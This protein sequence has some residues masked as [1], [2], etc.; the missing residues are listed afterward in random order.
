MLL[1]ALS[2]AGLE[3]SFVVKGAGAVILIFVWNIKQVLQHRPWALQH[4]HACKLHAIWR[5]STKNPCKKL[6][7]KFLQ[8]LFHA[9]FLHTNLS[10]LFR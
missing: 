9:D 5:I 7:S 3:I 2:L 6:A 10:V 4:L 1:V 8:E